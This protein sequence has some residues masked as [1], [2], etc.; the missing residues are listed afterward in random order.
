S[1]RRISTASVTRW[2]LLVVMV[3]AGGPLQ[4]IPS[5]GWP[6]FIQIT[7]V[8]AGVAA[9]AAIVLLFLP[10]SR[11]YFRAV[12]AL[13]RGQYVAKQGGAATAPRPTLRSMFAPKPAP[14]SLDKPRARAEASAAARGAKSKSRTEAEA[15]ARGAQLA[16]ERA[17]ASK[18]RRTD[19]S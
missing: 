11:A 18:S 7:L 10:D 9:I 16:R 17:K 12:A 15:V 2:A 14:V 5:S 1:L 6:P 19:S 4:V 8:L 3:L 13:R